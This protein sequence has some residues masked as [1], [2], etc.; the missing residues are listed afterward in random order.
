MLGLLIWGPVP[1]R[2]AELIGDWWWTEGRLTGGNRTVDPVSR[3]TPLLRWCAV[4]LGAG[5][6]S[7][8]CLGLALRA[9]A[10]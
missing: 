10:S 5:K 8:S 4:C 3:V 6:A 1:L 9:S 7:L 2:W